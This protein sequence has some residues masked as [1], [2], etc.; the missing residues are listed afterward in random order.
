MKNRYHLSPSEEELSAGLT[1]FVREK[2][3]TLCTSAHRGESPFPREVFDELGKLGLTGV[4]IP[5]E[6]GGLH[7]SS[8]LQAT[9]FDLLAQTDLGPAIFLSVHGMV[10]G[11]INR[12]GSEEQR[13]KLLPP[14]ARGEQLA[15]FALSEPEAGSDA[16]ALSTT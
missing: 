7:A 13:K 15:A 5:E 11:L 3:P 16:A 1:G 8:A 4:S 10:S 9:I 12:F 6:L 14:L 2:L